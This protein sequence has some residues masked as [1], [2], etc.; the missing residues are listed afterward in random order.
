[1]PRIATALCLSFLFA[2][3]NLSSAGDPI[4]HWAC[5]ETKSGDLPRYWRL[6]GSTRPKIE[7]E[8]LVYEYHA[9]G[10]RGSLRQKPKPGMPVCHVDYLKDGTKRMLWYA[11]YDRAFCKLRAE[12]LVEQLETGG[13]TCLSVEDSD[14][15]HSDESAIPE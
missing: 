5:F 2:S 8:I 7:R 1:M 9:S 14:R 12:R 15:F 6:I 3:S 13:L 10:G 4:T 11:R